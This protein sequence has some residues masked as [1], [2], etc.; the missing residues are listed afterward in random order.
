MALIS[1]G[2]YRQFE[3]NVIQSLETIK[4]KLQE[5]SANLDEIVETVAE[6]SEA[7]ADAKESATESADA[8]AA[9]ETAAGESQTA[10]EAA[11][12]AAEAA[13][14]TAAT[15]AS[16][17]AIA[18][19]EARAAEIEA[20]WPADYS[21]L[22]DDV[23]DLKGAVVELESA[24]EDIPNKVSKPSTNPDGTNGQILRTLGNGNTEW[25]S[26]G[27]P[28][29]AQTAEAVSDWLD[30]H[31]EAT[32]TVQDHS[33]TYDKLVTGTM[34]YV[35]PEMFGAKGDGVTDDTIAWQNAVNVG[36]PVLA[37]SSQ[38]KCGQINITKNI[39]VN[40]NRANF[41]C[42]S[43]T[44]FNCS[45]TV[46]GTDTGADY[47]ANQ[48]TYTNGTYTGFAFL[49]GTNNFMPSRDYYKG[50][51][52][53][54]FQ[55]GKMENQYPIPVTDV[56][57]ERITPITVN[58]H[59]IG[60]I[61]HTNASATN[62]SIHILCGLNCNVYDIVGFGQSSYACINLDK[63]LYCTVQNVAISNDF[64]SEN[65]NSYIVTFADSSYC[66]IENCTISNKLWHAVSTGGEYLCF[67]NAIKHSFLYSEAQYAFAD[68]NNALGTI[69]EDCTVR[70]LWVTGLC[71]VSNVTVLSSNHANG[72]A[73]I[74]LVACNIKGCAVYNVS[75]I[76]FDI[77]NSLTA[78]SDNGIILRNAVDVVT[79]LT[80][81]IDRV[82]ISNCTPSDGSRIT[83]SISSASTETLALG[84][85]YV[86]NFNGHI[87]A[88]K[89]STETNVNIANYELVVSNTENNTLSFGASSAMLFNIVRLVNCNFYE[90]RGTFVEF[91]FSNL[92]V[93]KQINTDTFT[94]S[95][96]LTG[97]VING[98]IRNPVL[99]ATTR[100]AIGSMIIND[101]YTLF[102][103]V[104]AANGD[105][106]YQSYNASGVLESTKIV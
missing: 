45:G 10:A 87:Y 29:D 84:K 49:K 96:L 8:A 28:T 98:Y 91:S 63:C 53:C 41:I 90:V 105:K 24:T 65:N 81:Y 73:S 7:A 18:A 47:S 106:Y 56:T 48:K 80:N 70:S 21:D 64:T 77:D 13:A 61:T 34:G 14:E 55:N 68:H 71:D 93:Y 100:L 51:F 16:A 69:I 67:K 82:S 75:D 54:M 102:N 72:R 25:V 86:D 52:A 30:A 104:N 37:M 2:R 78:S 4:N 62:I 38:Y 97:D 33:L 36:L 5:T 42:T 31:P 39:D 19:I 11:Q 17:L 92:T 95:N 76:I 79:G 94:V 12:E 58:L 50:G 9:S 26:V 22:T 83:L 44:L 35:T 74:N 15:D 60:T 89:G 1:E 32:T 40:C 6:A 99:L 20:D 27:L 103:I 43:T 66:S 85:V 59:N 3:H 23:T 101:T 46:D 57:I 88:G